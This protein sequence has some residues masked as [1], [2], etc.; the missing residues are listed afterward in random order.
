[1]K[2]VAANKRQRGKGF[3]VETSISIDNFDRT[4]SSC[5]QY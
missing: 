3:S 2:A 5:S 1:M 4:Y